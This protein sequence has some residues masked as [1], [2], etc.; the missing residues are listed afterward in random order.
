MPGITRRT[1]LRAFANTFKGALVAG[2]YGAITTQGMENPDRP[3]RR[4]TIMRGQAITAIAAL[5][6]AAG[7]LWAEPDRAAPA[8]PASEPP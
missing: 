7:A 6:A 5:G 1:V 2:T 4:D 8:V 3:D